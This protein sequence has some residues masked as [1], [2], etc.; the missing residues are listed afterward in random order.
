MKYN[1]FV[2]NHNYFES[3][4]YV[5]ANDKFNF[6]LDKYPERYIELTDQDGCTIY[7]NH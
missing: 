5:E 2:D 1:V 7:S 6:Y 3:D 4:S